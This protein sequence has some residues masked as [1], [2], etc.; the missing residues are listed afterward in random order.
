MPA[1]YEAGRRELEP[2]EPG[3]P[4]AATLTRADG[5][6]RLLAPEPGMWRV[7]ASADGFAP[8]ELPLLPLL[9]EVDAPD[10]SLPADSGLEVRVVSPAG[11]PVPGARV[12]AHPV[13]EWELRRWMRRPTWRAATQVVVADGRGRARL[14]AAAGDTWELEVQAPGFMAAVLPR[15]GP[16]LREIRLGTGREQ[17]MEVLDARG[18]PAPEVVVWSGEMRLPSGRSAEDGRVTLTLP[19]EGPSGL[20]CLAPD[21]SVLET[22]V[23]AADP[24]APAAPLRVRLEAARPVSGRV[25]D[26][27]RRE[28]AA[29]ALVWAGRDPAWRTTTVPRGD[30][31]LV[32]PPWVRSDLHAQA[33]GYFMEK[34]EVDP[35]APPPAAGPAFALEPTTSLVG[36][37]VD[38]ENQPVAAVEV[39]TWLV[40]S[41]PPFSFPKLGRTGGFT[42]SRSEGHF[43]VGNL[44]PGVTYR[45]R[46]HREGLAPEELR[47]R[48]PAVGEASPELRVVLQPGITTTGKVI[49]AGERPI[50][51]ATVELKRWH[52]G[53]SGERAFRRRDPDPPPPL[54]ATTDREGRFTLRDQSP[55]RFRMTVEAAGFATAEVP[56]VEI[57][58]EPGPADL[59]T[60]VL[61][62]EAPLEGRVADPEGQPLAGARVWVLPFDPLEEAMFVVQGGAAVAPD[63]LSDAGGWFRVPGLRAGQPVNLSVKLQG[64]APARVYGL[65]APTTEAVE[66]VLSPASR[67]SGRVVDLQGNPV[68]GAAVVVRPVR[69]LALGGGQAVTT[70][71][72]SGGRTSSGEDGAFVVE[73][74]EP[75]KADLAAE[76]L[77]MRE[78]VLRLELPPGEDLEGVEVVLEEAAAVSGRVLT[79]DGEPA[80]GAELRHAIGELPPGAMILRAPL[81]VT[82][83]E[84]RYRIEGLEPGPQTL[85]ARHEAHGRAVRDLDAAPGENTLDFQLEGGQTLAGTVVDPYGAPLAGA[86]VRLLSELPSWSYPQTVSGASGGFSFIGLQPGS[87]AVQ[88]EKDGV[89]RTAR[90]VP[91]EVGDGPVEGLT[92]ELEPVGSVFGSILG[93]TVDELARVQLQAGSEVGVGKVGYDGSYRILGL[94]LGKWRVAAR[95][96]RSGRQAQG[97]VKL[98]PELLE[99]HLDLDFGTGLTLAGQ[100]LLNGEAVAGAGVSAHGGGGAGGWTETDRAGRFELQGLEPAR[101]L[102]EVSHSGTGVSHAEWVELARDEEVLIELTTGPVAGVVLDAANSQPLAD[103]RVALSPVTGSGIP[104]PGRQASTGPDGSF[105]FPGVTTGNWRLTARKQ[106]YAPGELAVWVPDDGSGAEGLELALEPAA[107]LTLRVHLAATGRPATTVYLAVLAPTGIPFVA[108][109]YEAGQGGRINLDELRQ[110]DWALLVSAPGAASVRLRARVPSE[111]LT[112]SLPAAGGIRVRIPAL[113]ASGV[114][115]RARLLGP[116]GTAFSLVGPGGQVRGQWS[117][118]AGAGTIFGVPAGSW[119]LV[120][121]ADEDRVW[122][123][124]VTVPPGS[125]IEVELG[126][127]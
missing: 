74:V 82:D 85:V 53:D 83:G 17:T 84:G 57:P 81:A 93:L 70:T 29:G 73:E 95:L 16:G 49:D 67:V 31:S 117:V 97:V 56:G 99:A 3:E 107:G 113:A 75:G 78:K 108:G 118:E 114:G 40:R 94:T 105:R 88:A 71:G 34:A 90:P 116:G 59:G 24:E 39:R 127:S 92:V 104:S 126:D 80:I 98:T 111:P 106:G 103:A 12:R 110:G 18:R 63:A 9:E 6:Y 87:Y 62:P 64:F 22:R 76:A 7:V 23:P 125:T 35:T 45:L 25:L 52:G 121:T 109:T 124:P 15:V 27:F 5:G 86:L 112:V 8:R 1:P 66:V 102:L 68:A 19:E 55:G 43:R 100:V 61:E 14:P 89:G 91:V 119:V 26:L 54:R 46:F 69:F 28:P 4:A 48:A 122:S 79:E 77:G 32:L 36:T 10:L 123:A 33:P 42:R 50:A 47:V 51:G 20:R 96:T 44:A 115:G 41:G 30:Y 21:G 120:V 65:R 38:A 13:L 72:S 58:A 11:A 101:Y 37:V 2:A 60:V